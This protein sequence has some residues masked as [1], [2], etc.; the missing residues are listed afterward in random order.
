MFFWLCS[1]H[2][3]NGYINHLD[4][5]YVAHVRMKITLFIREIFS[6]QKFCRQKECREKMSFH[7][8]MCYYLNAELLKTLKSAQREHG[9]WN[10]KECA[11]QRF[12]CLS[13]VENAIL[14]KSI[15]AKCR[16]RDRLSL[17][18]HKRS[19]H[20]RLNKRWRILPNDLCSHKIV[21]ETKN[22]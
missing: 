11:Y 3:S 4:Q 9:K 15:C 13:W 10:C 14:H 6:A 17:S 7:V 8:N 19:H 21:V 18:S 20:L 1:N 5:L 2:P 12:Y 22:T 16:I